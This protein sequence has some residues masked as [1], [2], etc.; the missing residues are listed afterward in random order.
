M[1]DLFNYLPFDLISSILSYLHQV[2]CLEAMCVSHQWYEK[3]PNHATPL[4]TKIDFSNPWTKKNSRLLQCLG[5][6]VHIVALSYKQWDRVFRSFQQ[7][8]VVPE[9]LCKYSL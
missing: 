6:H 2:D 8:N 9:A 1:P 7:Y 4:W 3:M 5:P